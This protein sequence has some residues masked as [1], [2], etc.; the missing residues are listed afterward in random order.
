M[1]VTFQLRDQHGA[2]VA[3]GDLSPEQQDEVIVQESVWNAGYRAGLQDAAKAVL[4]GKV[5]GITFGEAKAKAQPINVDVTPQAIQI[6]LPPPNV[7]VN[8]PDSMRISS[9]PDRQTYRRVVRDQRGAIV[10]TADI[11]TDA[12]PAA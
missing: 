6:T 3:L 5:P 7:T 4:S 9:M 8:T 11:E 12:G 10:E 2:E 1:S